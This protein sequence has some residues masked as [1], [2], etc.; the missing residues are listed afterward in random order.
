MGHQKRESSEPTPEGSGRNGPIYERDI[1][2]EI[3]AIFARIPWVLIY[4][5][6]TGA[7]RDANGRLVRYGLCDG[8]AD[9]VGIVTCRYVTDEI[10]QTVVDVGRFLAIEVKRPGEKPRPEQ[11]AFLNR[12][13]NMGGVAGWC[14]SVAGAVAIVHE[15]R[16]F[17]DADLRELHAACAE[18]G[19]KRVRRARG[20]V[21]R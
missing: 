16:G 11:L 15:A 1:V 18:A 7:L 12:V 6:N 13:R 2:A 9:L 17:R 8:A 14:S 5:S 21:Q 3:R 20:V 10:R 19:S 4:R